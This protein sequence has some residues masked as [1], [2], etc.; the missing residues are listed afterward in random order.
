M[1]DRSGLTADVAFRFRRD[2]DWFV[3]GR[4]GGFFVAQVGTNSERAVDL[5][6]ALALHLD[7]AVDVYI[8]SLRDGRAWHGTSLAL[9][10]VREVVGRLRLP[11]AMHGGVEVAIV[12]PDDQLTLTPELQI[13][14]YA[15]TDR[16]Y[17]LLEGMGLVERAS[18]PAAVWTPSRSGLKPVPD[19]TNVLEAAADRLGLDVSPLS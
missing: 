9:P 7:P 5:L 10:D 2:N 6:P 3:A 1:A 4:R 18:P 13:V 17:F 19:V 15:R 8:E 16:W 12:T 14:V 11:L